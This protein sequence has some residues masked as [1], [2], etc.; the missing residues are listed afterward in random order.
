LKISLEKQTEAKI[1]TKC[2]DRE[3][4]ALLVQGTPTQELASEYKRGIGGRGGNQA[5]TKAATTAAKY[6]GEPVRKKG[7]TG[8]RIRGIV[9]FA[10]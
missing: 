1:K 7:K 9:D 3:T 10:T 5:T 2:S 4:R 8:P 6:L